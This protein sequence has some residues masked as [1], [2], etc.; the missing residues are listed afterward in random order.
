MKKLFSNLIQKTALKKDIDVLLD[1]LADSPRKDRQGVSARVWGWLWISL[2]PN[3]SC[4]PIKSC[5]MT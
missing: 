2:H 4:T 1:K 3:V 5:N